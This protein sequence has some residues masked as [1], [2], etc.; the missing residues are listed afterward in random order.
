[1]LGIPRKA[2]PISSSCAGAE[3]ETMVGSAKAAPDFVLVILSP[4]PP[5]QEG[6]ICRRIW[7]GK[8]VWAIQDLNL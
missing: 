5:F 3:K 7:I 8:E 4:L 2:M 6:G 1:M